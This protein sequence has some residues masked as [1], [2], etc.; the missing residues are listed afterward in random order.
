[1]EPTPAQLQILQAQLHTQQNLKS[2]VLF[3]ER[4]SRERLTEE[5]WNKILLTKHTVNLKFQNH[6]KLFHSHLGPTPS[7]REMWLN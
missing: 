2:M 1:M 3:I 6:L 5:A 7:M 4:E